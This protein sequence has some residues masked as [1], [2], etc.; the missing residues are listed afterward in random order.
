MIATAGWI[1]AV[2]AQLLLL[3]ALVPSFD[4][5]RTRH[6]VVPLDESPWFGATT[7]VAG[8]AAA[9]GWL[10]WTAS[11][12]FNVRRV[13]PLSTS[14]LLPLAVYLGG[15]VMVL[16]G[17]DGQGPTRTW[18]VALGSGWGGL[19][20]VVVIGSFRGAAARIGALPDE[21]AKLLWL[22]LAGITYR[23]SVDVVLE[24]MPAAWHSTP[25]LATLGALG[26]VFVWGMVLATWRATA[27]FDRACVRLNTRPLGAE[28]PGVHRVGEALR[29]ANG[30]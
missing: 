12:A 23:V 17:L 20:H 16:A 25:V 6:F 28:L 30:W 22:P 11:A 19:G 27:A 18:L 14:P 15:L 8:S 10:W 9:I 7:V 24:L 29:R 4:L 2:V 26:G 21:F 3:A 13:S 5:G 1:G